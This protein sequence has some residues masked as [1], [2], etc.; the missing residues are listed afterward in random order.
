M[1]FQCQNRRF[2]V[3]E[4]AYWK[5][6]LNELV[7]SKEQAKTLGLIFSLNKKQKI[8]KNISECTGS[9]YLLL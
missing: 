9:T 1:F 6:F 8:L 4:A 3:F 2:R 5:R 7:V